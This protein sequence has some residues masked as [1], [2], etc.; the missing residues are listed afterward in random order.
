VK[1]FV[2]AMNSRRRYS[3]FVCFIYGLEEKNSKSEVIFAV[4]R[5][6]LSSCLTSLFYKIISDMGVIQKQPFQGRCVVYLI[7]TLKEMP[8]NYAFVDLPF[9][10]FQAVKILLPA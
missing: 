5:L 2:F 7:F 9:F 10:I 3:T 1:L 6:L 8:F 4:C